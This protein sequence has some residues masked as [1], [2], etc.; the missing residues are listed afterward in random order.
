VGVD[1]HGVDEEN[2]V[3][4]KS[5][6]DYPTCVKAFV[7]SWRDVAER[8]VSCLWHDPAMGRRVSIEAR[9]SPSCFPDPWFVMLTRVLLACHALGFDCETS[10][11]TRCLADL[12]WHANE[13]DIEAIHWRHC[14]AAGIERYAALLI[15]FD[16][17]RTF[18][19]L[20]ERR[21]SDALDPT[22]LVGDIAAQV[23]RDIR[24]WRADGR[25]L[26]EPPKLTRPSDAI[27]RRLA[28]ARP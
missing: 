13:A 28:G 20:I 14:C 21:Q 17:R 19:D 24:K 6:F 7:L 2:V 25:N 3:S 8:F 11:I 16:R 23:V 15:D 26:P 27:K 18:H 22:E 10:F 9:L 12:G 5:I 1:A 4:R